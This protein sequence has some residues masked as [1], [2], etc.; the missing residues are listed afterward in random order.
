MKGLIQVKRHSDGKVFNNN[1][2][3][4]DCI[5]EIHFCTSYTQVLTQEVIDGVVHFGCIICD[6]LGTAPSWV[7]L[8]ATQN[9][10]HGEFI[11]E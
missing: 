11:E 2:S 3:Q 10:S 9:E 6:P 1:M 5:Y 8:I 4:F 7:D